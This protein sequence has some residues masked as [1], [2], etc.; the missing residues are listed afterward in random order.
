M[1]TCLQTSTQQMILPQ[2]LTEPLLLDDPDE[3]SLYISKSKTKI[4]EI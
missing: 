2:E 3:N 1:I 4:Q